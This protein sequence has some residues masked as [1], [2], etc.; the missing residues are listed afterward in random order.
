[1]TRPEYKRLLIFDKDGVLMDSSHRYRL[2]ENGLIDL[3]HWIDN[4]V[5]HVYDKPLPHASVYKAAIKCPETF[6]VIATASDL[7]T[8]GQKERLLSVLGAPNALIHRQGRSDARGGAELK[9]EGLK[10]LIDEHKLHKVEKVVYEDNPNYLRNI[11]SA[12][13]ATGVLVKS[14]QGH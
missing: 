1:M 2:K 3:K 6:V 8:H 12:L 7:T 4:E 11:T 5:N 9:I 10:Q 14:N 13:G